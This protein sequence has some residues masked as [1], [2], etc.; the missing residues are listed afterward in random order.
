MF[1]MN[2]ATKKAVD[3]HCKHIHGKEPPPN[4][5]ARSQPIKIIQHRNHEALCIVGSD[6]EAEL[7]WIDVED[8]KGCD[9]DDTTKQGDDEME[10][11]SDEFPVIENL[12]EWLGSPWTVDRNSEADRD[13]P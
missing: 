13:N 12:K 4:S 1:G 3:Q 8:L 10:S 6:K 2:L 11:E 7:E 5:C 9:V